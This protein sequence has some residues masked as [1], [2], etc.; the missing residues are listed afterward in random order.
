MHRR[1]QNICVDIVTTLLPPWMQRLIAVAMEL[2]LIAFCL[3]AAWL[4]ALQALASRGSFTSILRLPLWI[5]TLALSV[6]FALMAFRSAQYLWREA[7]G[8]RT[9]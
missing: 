9:R 4:G 5:N 8:S 3:Y 2:V 6:G 7:R 1:R